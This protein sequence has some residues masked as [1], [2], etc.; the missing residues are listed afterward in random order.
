MPKNGIFCFGSIDIITWY[1]SIWGSAYQN[2]LEP[3]NIIHRILIRIMMKNDFIDQNYNT[4]D[5]FKKLQTLTLKESYNK[6]S[7][8]KIFINKKYFKTYNVYNTRSEDNCNL[9]INKSNSTLM[10]NYY[11][12]RL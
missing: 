6:A 9:L 1:N 7:I 8:A 4:A 11:I 3:L 10:Q 12:T 2:V 5:L